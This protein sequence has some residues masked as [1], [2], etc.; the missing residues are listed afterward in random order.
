MS[1][2]EASVG[3]IF[4]PFFSIPIKYAAA[5]MMLV[6]VVGVLRAWKGFNHIA[7]LAG[8]I[9]GIGYWRW[10]V[11]RPSAHVSRGWSRRVARMLISFHFNPYTHSAQ[12]GIG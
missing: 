12:P 5:T 2:P 8:A 4:L 9:F 10:G 7:H 11:S 6:D 1:Y 3:I